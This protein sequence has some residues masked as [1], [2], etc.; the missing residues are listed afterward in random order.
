MPI[1]LRNDN[2]GIWY[3]DFTTQSGKRIRRSSGT[4]DKTAAQELH[5][6]LK[7][8]SWRVDKLG[9]RPNRT[10]D[11]ACVRFLQEK[12][13]KKS[14]NDDKAKIRALVTFR[15]KILTDL[16]RDFVME[17]INALEVADSTKNRY[18]ALIRA[19]LNLCAGEWEWI[20]KAPTI[21][22]KKEPRKRIR[23][24]TTDEASRLIEAL[25]EFY[26]DMAEFSLMT[27]LR[28]N[29]VLH[30]EWSQVDMKRKIAWIHPDQTKSGRPLGVPLND[31]A[32]SVLQRQMFRHKK[33]VFISNVTKG[34]IESVS[35]KAWNK[36]LATAGITNFRWHDMRHTWAS[37]L[38]QSGVPLMDLKEMGGW[39]TIEMVQRYAHLAPQH[40]H[41]NAMLLD[42]DVTN[43]AQLKN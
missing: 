36:A 14:L 12:G 39:E 7:H 29:N 27:G 3:I 28:Q 32:V 42:F 35:S 18:A 38:V 5:D 19:I 9:D 17:T 22:F 25:P 13:H 16:T 21:S 23:W 31:R 30:L 41:K 8:E 10:W 24:I 2:S 26:A 15:G 6:K 11:E 4:T 33:Y 20:E 34:P 43:S 1:Y 37:W 40:L